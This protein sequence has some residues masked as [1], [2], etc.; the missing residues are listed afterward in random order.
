MP[1]LIHLL[2]LA[3]L[4]NGATVLIMA[5]GADKAAP[6]RVVSQTVGTD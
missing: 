1:Y 4:L 2:L 6:H 3:L 5:E